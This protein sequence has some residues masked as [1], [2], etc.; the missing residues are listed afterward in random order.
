ML[1][2]E[3]KLKGSKADN[4]WFPSWSIG[5]DAQ[6][7]G[8]AFNNYIFLSTPQQERGHWKY[9]TESSTFYI[10]NMAHILPNFIIR[11]EK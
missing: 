3:G 2:Q 6:S 5:E 7:K 4:D 1:E 10:K 8:F 9:T 11:F